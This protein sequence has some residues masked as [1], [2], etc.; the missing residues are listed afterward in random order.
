MSHTVLPLAGLTP[1]KRGAVLELQLRTTA[2]GTSV[3]VVPESAM[4]VA[5]MEIH[6]AHAI[7]VRRLS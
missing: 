4:L 1:R 6:Y 5:L 3:R 2:L 7:H